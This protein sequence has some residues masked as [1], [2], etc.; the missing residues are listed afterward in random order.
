LGISI[1]HLFSLLGTPIVG[2]DR[3]ALSGGT[4]RTEV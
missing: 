1:L 2:C 4:T 3:G